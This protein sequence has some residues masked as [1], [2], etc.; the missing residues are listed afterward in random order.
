M[1][2]LLV[3][4][5]IVLVLLVVFY[6]LNKT[7][8]TSISKTSVINLDRNTDRLAIVQQ[9]YQASDIGVPLERFSAI[10]G[11]EVNL[12][13]WLTAETIS[14]L[15][16]IEQQGFRTKHHQLTRGAIGCYLSHLELLKRIKPGEVH[17]ILEDDIV[18]LF[19]SAAVIKN[20]LATAPSD[21]DFIL[22]GHNSSKSLAY[23][24]TLAK[25]KS[26]WGTCGYLVTYNGAQKF[27]RASGDTI[28]CQI[29]SFMSW[30]AAHGKLDI[31]ALKIPILQPHNKF[32]SD[33]QYP[34]KITG[35]ESFTYRDKIL[36]LY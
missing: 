12:Q 25:I 7:R 33:I 26:F 31:Y 17:L 8:A 19:K 2:V 21:W 32:D 14:E 13:N 20:T 5:L 16:E 18:I 3:P 1:K 6:L 15:T 27:I 30:M 11:H 34:I 23:S 36:Q 4:I 35:P 24:D 29:D 10:V 9:Q 22:L 28:D